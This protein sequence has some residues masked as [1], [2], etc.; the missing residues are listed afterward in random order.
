MNDSLNDAFHFSRQHFDEELLKVPST[1]SSR[2]ELAFGYSQ[3]L[4]Q[5]HSQNS[6]L[7]TKFVNLFYWDR[8]EGHPAD[9]FNFDR[10]PPEST[11]SDWKLLML[12][13]HPRMLSCN[14]THERIL[15]FATEFF[16]R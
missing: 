9:D 1:S 7:K 11:L 16:R 4:M 15:R 5:D 6:E 2:L 13:F 10:F 8:T 14:V 12:P 3:L